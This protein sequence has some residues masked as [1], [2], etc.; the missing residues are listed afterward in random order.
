MTK[1]VVPESVTIIEGSTF[2]YTS[3][4][5]RV[6]F[7]HSDISKLA[8]AEKAFTNGNS[9]VVY[10]FYDYENSVNTWGKLNTTNFTNSNYHQL[11]KVTYDSNGG[12]ADNTTFYDIANTIY[13]T[14][15]TAG[16]YVANTG[17]RLVGW[18]TN[19][20]GT[21]TEYGV[22]VSYNIPAQSNHDFT[23]YAIWHAPVKIIVSSNLNTAIVTGATDSIA[24]GETISVSTE[25]NDAQFTFV[26]WYEY[27]DYITNVDNATKLSGEANYTFVVNK[28]IHLFAVYAYTGSTEVHIGHLAK[29]VWLQNIVNGGITF[30]GI[31]F[32]LDCDLN[33]SGLEDAQWVGIGND[34]YKFVG[35]FN[36]L[37]HKLSSDTEL[38]LFADNTT[39]TVRNLFIGGSLN[40]NIT[41]PIDDEYLIQDEDNV[42]DDNTQDG[43]NKR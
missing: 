25:T 14:P 31:T 24:Y 26:G 10:A 6:D 38:N 9:G 1:L 2:E 34:T 40:A 32:Y 8:L 7:L 33:L 15:A 11:Y 3:G 41:I 30:S 21:G 36:G 39:A 16:T 22:G 5:V 42:L 35:T 19:A 18:N 28:A 20:N 4:L 23:L 29:R 12:D 27:D 43:Q 37:G 13:T 17:Y